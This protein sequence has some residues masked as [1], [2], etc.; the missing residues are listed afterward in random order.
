MVSAQGNPDSFILIALNLT[1]R[2]ELEARLLRAQK[3]ES[4]GLIGGGVAHDFNNLLA[5]IMGNASMAIEALAREHPAY[6]PVN[7]IMIASRH[8]SDLTQQMLTYCGR[9]N[10]QVKPI[11]LSA[12]VREIG[13]LLE[14]T[15]SKKI[16][17]T[18]DLSA[19]L[20][21]ID[22]DPGQVQQVVRTS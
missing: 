18:F 1:E 2:R 6:R 9:A 4:L 19:G 22:A 3:M 14:T 20:P 5:T 12:L 13:T 17:L 16:V 21:F 10:V 15:I 11:D 7:E 8:A